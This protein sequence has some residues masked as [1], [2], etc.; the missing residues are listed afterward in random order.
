MRENGP[1][2]MQSVPS[3]LLSLSK[4]FI[5]SLLFGSFSFLILCSL[6]FFLIA[7][8]SRKQK[9]FSFSNRKIDLTSARRF[10]IFIFLLKG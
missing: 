3:S 10:K 2:V 5:S 9:R 7:T 6:F 4:L 1:V 8:K